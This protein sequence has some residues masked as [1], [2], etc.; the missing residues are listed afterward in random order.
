MDSEPLIVPAPLASVAAALRSGELNLFDYIERVCDRLD[1]VNPQIQAFLPETNRRARIR[2]DA[3]ALAQKY[4][5]P[6]NRPALYGVVIGVKDIFR[7]DRFAT[8]AGSELPPTLFEGPEALCVQSLR[9]AG[10]LVLGKT[11]TTEFAYFE[12]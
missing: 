2:G 7:V 8:Q 12:P 11:V 6:E 3:E 10:A 5:V 1:A 4:P 9:K